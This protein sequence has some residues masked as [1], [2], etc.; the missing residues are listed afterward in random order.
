[1]TCE[2]LR[3][4]S[5]RFSSGVTFK[6]L[7][8]VAQ[9]ISECGGIGRPSRDALRSFRLLLAWFRQNWAAVVPWLALVQ[10]RDNNDCVIDGTR[11][12]LEKGLIPGLF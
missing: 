12:I 1:M 8:S 10:L 4:L 9:I 7:R 5:A 6:E 11:E 2:E 3:A